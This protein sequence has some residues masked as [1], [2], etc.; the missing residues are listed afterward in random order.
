ML[1]RPPQVSFPPSQTKRLR[2][3]QAAFQTSSDAENNLNA[4]DSRT[5]RV[6]SN[7]GNNS[8][9]HCLF[10]YYLINT[11]NCNFACL[12]KIIWKRGVAGG[13][14]RFLSLL[15]EEMS[16]DKRER[17][18]KRRALMRADRFTVG[19]RRELREW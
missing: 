15:R 1:L 5:S 8:A 17:W 16:E 6:I 12:F 11:E 4:T 18:M 3:E 7:T 9:N 19:Q 10:C 2:H 13:K 14:R